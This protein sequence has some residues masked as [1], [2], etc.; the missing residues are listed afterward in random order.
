MQITQ[1]HCLIHAL[2]LACEFLPERKWCRELSKES[3]DVFDKRTRVV[4]WNND[5]DGFDGEEFLEELF[6]DDRFSKSF[7]KSFKL[8][9]DR[10]VTTKV[11]RALRHRRTIDIEF[12]LSVAGGH[13]IRFRKLLLWGIEHHGFDCTG[14]RIER[15]Y[16]FSYY[17]VGVPIL[18]FRQLRSAGCFQE[19]HLKPSE[20]AS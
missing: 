3:R 18:F 1:P 15:E 7:P 20:N 17:Q 8:L 4:L 14:K 13:C 5:V 9:E 11:F 19:H 10:V 12:K 16:N 2:E 6:D